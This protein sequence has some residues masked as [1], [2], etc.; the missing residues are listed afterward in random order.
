MISSGHGPVTAGHYSLVRGLLG[1]YLITHFS[2]LISYG[3]ELFSSDGLLPAELS[4]LLGIVPNPLAVYDA[5]ITVTLLLVTGVLCGVAVMLGIFDRVGGL[6]AS[7]ILAWLFARNP[8]I[9]NPSMPVV[10]WM[11][12]VN[13][14]LPRG[15]Y[16]QLAARG[17]PERW[18]AWFYPRPIWIA[19][20]VLLAVAYSYSGYTKLLSP[21][22]VDGTAI[23]IVLE[24]PLARD[25]FLRLMV[26][27]LPPLFLSVLTWIVLVIELLF[28]PLCF[29]VFTRRWAWLSML[30]IQLGFLLLLDFADLTFPMLLIHALTFDRRW[31]SKYVP[32][33]N[34]ILFYDG[35]CGFCNGFVR[36]AVSEDV[37]HKLE[38]APLEGSTFT[39]NKLAGPED[40]SIVLYRHDGSTL[41][42]SDAAIF[43]M[44]SLGG[45]WLVLGMLMKIVPRSARDLCYDFVGRIRY[46]LGGKVDLEA[47]PLLPP[48]YASRMLP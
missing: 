20:W 47:C 28:V 19:S 18:A 33:G 11:L 5:P 21:S 4:P 43:C 3:T 7:V 41:Y 48:K 30:A 36:F 2:Q 22:W 44:R 31:L 34:S 17:Q 23:Q 16:G 1:I 40:D 6:V 12:L 25:H 45:V 13:A 42:K 24:N 14:I 37:D 38:F 8:L 27:A 9:A 46:Q 39:G 32:A 15:A 10:G 35:T 29:W 26:L